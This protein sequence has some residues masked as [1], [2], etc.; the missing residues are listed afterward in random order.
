VVADILVA[1]PRRV[2]QIAAW[3]HLAVMAQQLDEDVA[4]ADLQL[5]LRAIDP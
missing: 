1:A 4:G 5:H 2:H 3:H